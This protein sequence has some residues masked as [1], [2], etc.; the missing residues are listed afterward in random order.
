[1]RRSNPVSAFHFFVAV[2]FVI[3]GYHVRRARQV[4]YD[5][6][7]EFLCIRYAAVD[8]ASV[9]SPAPMIQ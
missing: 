9:R 8:I 7:D 4:R 2:L 3:A 5:L 6:L 1:M